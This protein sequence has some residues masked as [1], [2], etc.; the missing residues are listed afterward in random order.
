[1]IISAISDLHGTLPTIR[2]CDICIIAGDISPLRIQNSIHYTATWL[3][4]KFKDWVINLPCNA[5][6]AIWGNH[7]FIGEKAPWFAETLCELTDYKLTWLHGQT[8]EIDGITIYG[9]PY[10]HQF[11]H[12]PFM[13][14]ESWL[15]GYYESIPDK[16]DILVTHDTPALGDLDLLPASQWNTKPVHAGGTSLAKAILEKKPK[17]AL[18]GHLHTCKDKFW[19][20][21]NTKIY[22][23]SILNNEYENV[24]NPTYIII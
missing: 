7:D 20:N 10:C 24:Y 2:P 23:V 19:E 3:L 14:S 21:E 5:V 22:N 15:Q 18:C 8:D 4:T 1:M 9:S 13:Q 12:W 17:I 11:G 6:Y 16:V